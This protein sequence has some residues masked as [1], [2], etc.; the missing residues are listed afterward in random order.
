MNTSHTF[1]NRVANPSR[2]PAPLRVERIGRDVRSPRKLVP[3]ALCFLVAASLFTACNR[4][5]TPDQGGPGSI[6]EGANEFRQ[7]GNPVAAPDAQ[8][9]YG[10]GGTST[11][12]RIAAD[13]TG[14]IE[15]NSAR[16]SPPGGPA[17]PHTLSDDELARKVHVA[18]STGTTGTTG[19]YAPDML[20][21]QIS[22][23]A[24][25]GSVTLSGVVGSQSA[26]TRFGERA[27]AI[28]G[29]KE[30]NN[31]LSVSPSAPGKGP[32]PGAPSGRGQTDVVPQTS[33]QDIRR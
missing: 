29:V 33:E 10:K 4:N 13:A 14:Q 18:L 31:Q 24:S 23:T 28:Q 15:P 12:S 19:A 2:V 9:Q 16:T 26:K 8:A 5:D 22:V 20:L 6:Q 7:T 32:F 1:A 21:D 25:N 27:R 17:D 30:V 3:L 11:T